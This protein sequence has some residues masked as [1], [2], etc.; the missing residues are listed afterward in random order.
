[1]VQELREHSTCTYCDDLNTSG[2]ITEMRR[3]SRQ[4]RYE[5]LL[6]VLHFL[7]FSGELVKI[8]RGVVAT[9]QSGLVTIEV[10]VPVARTTSGKVTVTESVV[11]VRGRTI[12]DQQIKER[13][14]ARNAARKA[15]N[16]AEADRIRDE[17][18]AMGIALH[19][20]KE[21][22]TWEVKR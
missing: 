10:K 5:D 19:D 6:A 17:L 2:V 21:G 16:W 13:I 15:K 9:T 3:L 14:A 8:P 22:T 4:D 18:D 7:G 20:T 11:V 12:P 1:L